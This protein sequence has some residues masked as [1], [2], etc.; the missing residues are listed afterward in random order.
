MKKVMFFF[1]ALAVCIALFVPVQTANAMPY[2]EDATIIGDEVNMRMRPTTDAP[3]ILKLDEGTRIGVFCEEVEGWY[4]IIYGNYR[5]YISADYVFLPSTDYMIANVL[6]GGLNL[7]Q[8]PGTYSS[9]IKK[10]NEGTGLKIKSFAGDWYYVELEETGADGTVKVTNG[11]VH[12][13]YVKIS[14]AKQVSNLLKIGMSGAEVRNLQQKLRERG[15]MISAATGYFGDVTEGAVKA[16]QKKA[17]LDRDGIVG[18][19]T[20]DMIFGDNDIKTTTAEMFGITGEVRLS[21]WDDIKK[22]FTKGKTAL[23]TDVRTGKQFRVQ[24][25]GG[26]FHADCEPLTAKDTAIMKECYGGSWSWD[27]R[28]IWVT[29]GSR[30]YAASQNGMPHLSSPIGGN[31]FDGHFCIHFKDSKVHQTSRECP[32]HQAA[33]NYA[34]KKAH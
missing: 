4:R 30:T 12:K 34:Y 29:I 14:K 8:N 33:V 10:L 22:V 19:Q 26:W 5:G 24:R 3:I 6:E 31:N 20:Y 1:M 11:Y 2:F 13:D 7:R 9:V 28:A 27:R 15:F 25:F 17:H 18:A 16:F 23:V 21:T 32:R